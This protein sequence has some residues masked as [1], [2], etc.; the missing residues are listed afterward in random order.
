MGRLVFGRGFNLCDEGIVL[1]SL[2]SFILLVH[3]WLL[4]DCWPPR[5]EGKEHDSIITYF[6]LFVCSVFL[7]QYSSILVGSQGS[8]MYSKGSFI[9]LHLR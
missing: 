9:L 4:Y 1:F 7:R 3:K 6:F 2:H 5:W 8:H